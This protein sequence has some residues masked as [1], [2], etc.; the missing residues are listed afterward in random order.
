MPFTQRPPSQR[1]VPG[2]EPTASQCWR[3]ISTVPDLT[4]FGTRARAAADTLAASPSAARDTARMAAAEA[5]GE[6]SERILRANR[7]DVDVAVKGGLHGA[8][9]DR[10]TLSETRLS[11]M[12]QSLREIA[13]LVDPVGEVIDGWRRP[14]G[15]DIRRVRVPLGVVA[16]IYEARPNVTSDVFG[17][18]LKSGNATILRGSATALRSNTAVVEVLRAAVAATGLPADA[19]QLFPDTTRDGAVSLLRMLE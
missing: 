6:A 17:L 12:A 15:L 9:V 1:S 7:D 18:C 14:N 11:A 13:A 5:L 3:S 2:S 4:D 8:L 16:V 19:L 10:L